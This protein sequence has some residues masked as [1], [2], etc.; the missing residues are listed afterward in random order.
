[1]PRTLKGKT[2]YQGHEAFA[3]KTSLTVLLGTPHWHSCHW[4]PLRHC[5]GQTQGKPRGY[6][7]TGP[8]PFKGGSACLSDVRLLDS[9]NLLLCVLE[10]Q[11]TFSSGSWRQ[12][13]KNTQVHTKR[14]NNLFLQ[15][16]LQLHLD[17]NSF[18]FRGFRS[19]NG[20]S[21][22]HKL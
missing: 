1:M 20:G 4:P 15:H 16:L 18:R 6:H 14:K 9:K 10:E 22:I 17:N 12:L 3:L 5:I 19:S 8:L 11:V 2:H 7:S 21:M 13:E